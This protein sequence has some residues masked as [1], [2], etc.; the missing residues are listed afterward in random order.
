MK[1]NQPQTEE[2]PPTRVMRPLAPCEKHQDLTHFDLAALT[3]P[4]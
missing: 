2:R 1:G 4:V 3:L